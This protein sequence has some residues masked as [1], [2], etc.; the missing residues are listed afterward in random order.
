MSSVHSS[1]GNNL[2]E[3]VVSSVSAP[4]GISKAILPSLLAMLP[5]WAAETSSSTSKAPFSP[6]PGR[7]TRIRI[8]TSPRAT[9]PVI[10]LVLKGNR[11]NLVLKAASP[12][13][14]LVMRNRSKILIYFLFHTD[15]LK[16]DIHSQ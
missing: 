7:S 1:S 15:N 11:L 5:P 13:L 12:S 14:D 16:I 8:S 10:T 6:P 4:G 2:I 3:T 9:A